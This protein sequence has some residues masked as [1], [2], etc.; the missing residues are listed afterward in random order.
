MASSGME[1][2][3]ISIKYDK[4]P[5]IEF[6]NGQNPL[7][8]TIGGQTRQT[9]AFESSVD[10]KDSSSQKMAK[11]TIS[12]G[13]GFHRSSVDQ[14]TF[15]VSKDGTLYSRGPISGGNNEDGN[16]IL[17][18]DKGPVEKLVDKNGKP[19]VLDSSSLVAVSK[20]VGWSK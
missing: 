11:I 20:H 4:S 16:N 14:M 5:I 19:I 8:V 12:N 9:H 17:R 2:G 10:V 15:F 1:M 3:S 6:L 7:Q 13:E 18:E